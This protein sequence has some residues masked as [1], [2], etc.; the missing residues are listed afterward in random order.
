MCA[1]VLTYAES[2]TLQHDNVYISQVDTYIAAKR[3]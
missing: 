2:I 1:I 3:V